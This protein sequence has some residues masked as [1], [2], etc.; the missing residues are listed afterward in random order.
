MKLE[1][2]SLRISRLLSQNA[3]RISRALKSLASGE[4][5]LSPVDS[6]TLSKLDAKVRGLR[7]SILNTN[8]NVAQID[9]SMATID[10]QLSLIN[11]LR[12]LAIKANG[13]LSASERSALSKEASQL[14]QEYSRVQQNTSS[15][16][17]IPIADLSAAEIFKKNVGT[18]TF[19]LRSTL[20][21]STTVTSAASADF[22]G[23]G[24]LDYARVEDTG[25]L[26]VFLGDG[27]GRFNK[28]STF[29]LVDDSSN[30]GVA[31]VDGDGDVDIIT[32]SFNGMSYILKN[33]GQGRFTSSNTYYDVNGDLAIG[34]VD[35]DGDMDYFSSTGIIKINDGRGNF[36]TIINVGS[37][38][39]ISPDD[40]K[41]VDL[42][43]DGNNDL[44]L[45]DSI[46]GKV[47]VL[48]GLG[49]GSFTA[50]SP[51]TLT[52][53][54][55]DLEISDI[56]GDGLKDF[57]YKSD[58]IGDFYTDL[59]QGGRS[60]GTSIK[61]I[62]AEKAGDIAI[63]DYNRDGY[64]D[65]I[66]TRLDNPTF[67]VFL[68]NGTGNF[69]LSRQDTLNSSF[70][71][72]PIWED[73]NHDGIID[74]I[75]NTFSGVGIFIGNSTMESRTNEVAQLGPDALEIIDNAQAKILREQSKLSI[76]RRQLEVRNAWQE[77][78]LSISQE[79]KEELESVDYALEMADLV[80]A[81]IQ[82]QAQ[83]AAFSQS[84]VQIQMIGQL[85]RW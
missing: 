36:D 60:F 67:I 35:N 48:W 47:Q 66:N 68:G 32:S 71:A 49:N 29:D 31:D 34:D 2:N 9:Q 40:S 75:D 51:L 44:L 82:S 56:N 1:F 80:A 43:N 58:G 69:T 84:L 16:A 38:Y 27:T 62:S 73:F 85:L 81:Q 12:D 63:V 4:R 77:S 5:A 70:R 17:N 14:M 37:S 13:V 10:Q 20:A 83:V 74:L 57:V 59:N 76:L 65:V 53:A 46:T 78:D 54:F 61:N 26:N 64:L 79:I 22:N 41:I 52:V 3:Q 25:I 28:V 7:Q 30:I 18:G 42:D 72:A 45:E 8:L 33:N 15:P 55:S 24:H 50:S 6:S 11:K 39:S 19:T 21:G 23:D